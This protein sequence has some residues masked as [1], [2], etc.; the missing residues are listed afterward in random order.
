MSIESTGP[1]DGSLN[2]L[3]LTG[4]RTSGLTN[5]VFIDVTSY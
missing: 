2:R 4:R 3:C 5:R 1:L